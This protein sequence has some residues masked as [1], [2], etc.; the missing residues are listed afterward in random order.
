MGVGVPVSSIRMQVLASQLHSQ[1]QFPT[2]VHSERH[3]ALT[4]VVG[5]LPPTWEARFELLAS[6]TSSR[7]TKSPVMASTLEVN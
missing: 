6:N 2:F 5:F 3:K 7:Y 4:K 1:L